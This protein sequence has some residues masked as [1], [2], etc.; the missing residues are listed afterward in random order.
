[1]NCHSSEITTVKY[2][3]HSAFDSAVDSNGI[4]YMYGSSCRDVKKNHLELF[5]FKL[6]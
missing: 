2:A 5:D 6:K 3:P 4:H 1:M